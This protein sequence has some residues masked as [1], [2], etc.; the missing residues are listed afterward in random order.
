MDRKLH[1]LKSGLILGELTFAYETETLAKIHIVVNRIVEIGDGMKTVIP[2][3]TYYRE[4]SHETLQSIDEVKSFDVEYFEGVPDIKD[5]M[6]ESVE[7]SYPPVHYRYVIGAGHTVGIADILA[8]FSA[9]KKDVRFIS[10]RGIHHDHQMPSNSLEAN[11][12]LLKRLCESK[13]LGCA[14]ANFDL[15]DPKL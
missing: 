12:D 7:F 15:V 11:V 2:L 5:Q 1:V 8:D 6:D 14:D 13:D 9:D 3:H 4:I 10:A